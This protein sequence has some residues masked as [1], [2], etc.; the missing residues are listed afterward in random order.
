M[1]REIRQE[2]NHFLKKGGKIIQKKHRAGWAPL[3][4]Y[5]L[6]SPLISAWCCGAGALYAT[7]YGAHNHKNIA[8]AF[9]NLVQS[10]LKII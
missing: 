4:P 2:A 6:T 7:F 1:I 9:F 5:V 3:I 10:P 8:K